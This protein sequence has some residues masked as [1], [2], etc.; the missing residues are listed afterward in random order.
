MGSLLGSLGIGRERE[1]NKEL[2]NYLGEIGRGPLDLYAQR[3]LEMQNQNR[4][5]QNLLFGGAGYGGSF[6]PRQ[7]L[8]NA[9][10]TPSG[11]SGGQMLRGTP[12]TGGQQGAT[13]SMGTPIGAAAGG[14]PLMNSEGAGQGSPDFVDSAS[15]MPGI[16]GWIGRIFGNRGPRDPGYIDDRTDDGNDS[17]PW[18]P[19][20][21]DPS[22]G[23]DSVPWGPEQWDPSYGS[24]AGGYGNYGYGGGGSGT[25]Y[26]T[27]GGGSAPRPNGPQPEGYPETPDGVPN[28]PGPVTAN[29]GQNQ[30]LLDWLGPQ[31]NNY[32]DAWSTSPDWRPEAPTGGLYGGWDNFANSSPE[33]EELGVLAEYMRRMQD[34]ATQKDQDIMGE[35]DWMSSGLRNGDEEAEMWRWRGMANDPLTGQDRAIND[36]ARTFLYNPGATGIEG[37]NDIDLFKSFGEYSRTPGRGENEAFGAYNEM[38]TKPGYSDSQSNAMRQEGMLGARAAADAAQAEMRQRGGTGAGYY[39]NAAKLAR[40]TSATIGQQARQN[41]IALANEAIR[42]REV[43]ASG[44]TDLA[45]IGNRR[46]EFGAGN[47]VALQ[48]GARDARQFGLQTLA[49]RSDEEF[50]RRFAA[51]GQLSAQNQRQRATA[52]QGLGMAAQRQDEMQRRREGSAQGVTDWYSGQRN[53]QAAGLQGLGS[54]YGQQVGQGQDYFSQIMELL[55]TPRERYQHN[56]GTTGNASVS[57]GA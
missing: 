26:P 1:Y 7:S 32:S 28:E 34:P 46:F 15:G 39:N 25:G 22:D 29:K 53:R 24:P 51:T 52:A 20:D 14:G 43:G 44:M 31:G 55:R 16:G 18:N 41:E 5:Q 40:D 11:S 48:Q 57:G 47:Q 36:D 49:N 45:N 33:E 50:N 35:L 4:A 12:A 38:L 19:G 27:Q 23:G 54:L 21:W 6:R 10:R 2:Y 37:V 9:G 42:Q 17:V 3:A 30:D 8:G 56:T 13:T